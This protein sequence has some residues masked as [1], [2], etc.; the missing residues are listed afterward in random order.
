MTNGA[1]TVVP[2]IGMPKPATTGGT[3]LPAEATPKPSIGGVFSGF[4]GFVGGI[5]G[6]FKGLT[7]NPIMLLIIM[8]ALVFVI[9]KMF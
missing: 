2:T 5:P 6:F 9:G 3:L 4:G 8:V 1:E 7:A